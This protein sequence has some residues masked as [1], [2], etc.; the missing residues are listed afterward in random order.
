MQTTALVVGAAA[1]AAN[2]VSDFLANDPTVKGEN[3]EH[4]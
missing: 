2:Q 3:N 1:E 4:S